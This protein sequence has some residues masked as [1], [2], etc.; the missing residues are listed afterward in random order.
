MSPRLRWTLLATL[1]AGAVVLSLFFLEPKEPARPAAPV[2]PAAPRVT[3]TEVRLRVTPAGIEPP[4][5]RVAAGQPLTLLVTRTT[6]QTC[7]T[8]LEVPGGQPERVLLPLDKTVAIALTP[9][10]PGVLR[11][12]CTMGQMIGG[13]LRFE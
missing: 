5:V 1:V 2:R 4:E 12:G 7:A 10:Q 3:G 8:E 11:Y 6:E 9:Q 13:V